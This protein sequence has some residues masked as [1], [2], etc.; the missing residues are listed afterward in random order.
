V[1]TISSGVIAAERSVDGEIAENRTRTVQTKS[2]M[3][4]ELWLGNLDLVVFD[5]RF[6]SIQDLF[7]GCLVQQTLCMNRSSI[8][9]R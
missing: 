2:S 6:R 5:L 3:L 1:I 9:R 4:A 7:I 8:V